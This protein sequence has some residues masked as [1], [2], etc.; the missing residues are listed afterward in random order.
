MALQNGGYALGGGGHIPGSSVFCVLFREESGGNES[1][2]LDLFASV[3]DMGEGFGEGGL[4]IS[5]I[6][7]CAH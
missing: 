7:K 1:F 2:E 5:T 4:E 6:A 3:Y